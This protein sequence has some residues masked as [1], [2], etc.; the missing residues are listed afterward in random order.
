[1]REQRRALGLTAETLGGAIGFP[2]NTILAVEIG[3]SPMTPQLRARAEAFFAKEL[4]RQPAW[5]GQLP[6]DG[7]V[8]AEVWVKPETLTA[9]LAEASRRDVDVELVLGEWA[10]RPA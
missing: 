10:D 6:P 5:E 8:R 4:L 2:G 7:L 3:A 9:A 1:M